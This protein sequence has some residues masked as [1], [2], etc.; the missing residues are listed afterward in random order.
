MIRYHLFAMGKFYMPI[1]KTFYTFQSQNEM[2][3]WT[4][5]VNYCNHVD[6]VHKH[7]VLKVA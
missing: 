5:Q 3:L 4:E 7:S 1:I 6:M 2:A